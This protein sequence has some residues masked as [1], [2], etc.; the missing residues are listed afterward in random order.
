MGIA[1]KKMT[2]SVQENEDEE[3][4]QEKSSLE[5]EWTE[6]CNNQLKVFES[7]WTKKL[8]DYGSLAEYEEPFTFKTSTKLVA[9]NESR[10]Y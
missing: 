3:D 7:K 6:F 1:I 10:R 9:D 5:N 2:E 8:E 4:K